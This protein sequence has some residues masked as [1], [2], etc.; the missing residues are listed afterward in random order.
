MLSNMRRHARVHTRSPAKPLEPVSDED[1]EGLSLVRP[2]SSSP[3]GS[4]S[5]RMPSVDL[6]SVKW[7]YRRTSSASTSSGTSQSHSG[8][9]LEDNTALPEGRR[10]LK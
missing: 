4:V 5:T 8:D 3:R 7:H 10:R 9:E 1:S 6:S 2:S